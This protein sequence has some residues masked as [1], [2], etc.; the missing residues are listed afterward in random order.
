MLAIALASMLFAAGCSRAVA[1]L[2]G[3]NSKPPHVGNAPAAPAPVVKTHASPASTSAPALTLHLSPASGPPGTYVTVSGTVPAGRR[4]EAAV[5]HA[6]VC[7]ASCRSGLG[8]KEEAVRVAWSA[9]RPGAFALRMRVPETPWVMPGGVRPITPGTY[10]IGVRCLVS[11]GA[12][13]QGPRE[14]SASFRL[15]GPTST[16]CT[17]GQP[18]GH[19]MLSPNSGPPGTVVHLSGWAPLDTVIGKP[20]DFYLGLAQSGKSAQGLGIARVHQHFDGDLYGSF[21]L[22]PSVPGIGVLKAGT[23]DVSAFA[24]FEPPAKV[25]VARAAFRVIAPV[26]W[27]SL[28]RL[29]PAL[30]QWAMPGKEAA[31][32][33]DPERVARCQRGGTIGL[34]SDGAKTWV[35]VPT[36]GVAAALKGSPYSVTWGNS[37]KAPACATVLPAPGGRAIFA[38]FDGVEHG[39]PPPLY[40]LPFLTTDGGQTWRLLPAPA[41]YRPSAFS[42]FQLRGGAVQALF[43]GGPGT[44]KA[45]L[46]LE[47]TTDGGR[48]WTAGSLACPP[49]G[50][51]VIWGPGPAWTWPGV[52]NAQ[53][54]LW[55]ADGGRAWSLPKWPTHVCYVGTGPVGPYELATLADGRVALLGGATYPLRLTAD[56]GRTWSAVQVP[57]LPHQGSAW[58][59]PVRLLHDGTLAASWSDAWY[60][61]RPAGMAWCRTSAPSSTTVRSADTLICPG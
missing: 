61:L 4:P 26:T 44:A 17:R 31:D 33:T 37:R 8:L 21:V 56:G 5:T 39:S 43:W 51:C 30:V 7:W 58:Y 29:Q 32:P 2:H 45:R 40:W 35:T 13:V 3:V 27:A 41:G 11:Q 49:T 54:V 47:Q 20:F 55:S 36:A 38:A 12:C 53:A 24:F 59:P 18:C 22:P 52:C 57:R 15:T 25:V 19:L 16:A 9:S 6:T 28:G 60:V 42:R 50:P 1:P 34:S 46:G 14:G 48:T 23:A 10:R